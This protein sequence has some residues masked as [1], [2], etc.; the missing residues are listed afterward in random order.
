MKKRVYDMAGVLPSS[1]R[2][3]LN[4]K[5]LPITNFTN[6]VNMYLSEEAVKI[7]EKCKTSKKK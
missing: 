3:Y 2:V 6:Y 4:D 7:S 1:V 5:K